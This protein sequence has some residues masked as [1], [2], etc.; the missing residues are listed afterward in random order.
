M[1]STL[2]V[3]GDPFPMTKCG[4]GV[5]AGVLQSRATHVKVTL[6]HSK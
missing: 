2:V 3:E 4:G 1:K 5:G 6:D